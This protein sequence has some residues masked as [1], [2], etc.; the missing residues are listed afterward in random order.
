MSKT[1]QRNDGQDFD[2]VAP[3]GDVEEALLAALEQLQ[4][5][6]KAAVS[7][8]LIYQQDHAGV[9]GNRFAD[10]S[11]MRLEKIR[12][13]QVELAPY[14]KPLSTGDG[15]YGQRLRRFG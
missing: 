11:R 15:P 10:A 1:G 13:L 8:M 4:R 7:E 3:S 12:V 6:E 2:L 5:A 9:V 14:V